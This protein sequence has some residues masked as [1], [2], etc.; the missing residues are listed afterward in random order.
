MSTCAQQLYFWNPNFGCSDH[1]IA[2]TNSLNWYHR[3]FHKAHEL[4]MMDNVHRVEIY[5]IMIWQN[6]NVRP[7]IRKT[8]VFKYLTGYP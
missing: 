6:I 4:H 5:E 7:Q 1:Y 3:G 2:K 8:D